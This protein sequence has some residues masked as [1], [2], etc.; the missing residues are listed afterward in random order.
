MVSAAHQFFLWI[1]FKAFEFLQPC[2]L[3]L[4]Y[5]FFL[6]LIRPLYLGLKQYQWSQMLMK[7]LS[8]KLKKKAPGGCSINIGTLNMHELFW[9]LQCDFNASVSPYQEWWIYLFRPKCRLGFCAKL[10]IAVYKWTRETLR[11]VDPHAIYSL[12]SAFP[13]YIWCKLNRLLN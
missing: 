4:V 9:M 6:S 10:G 13:C 11:C 12:S 5:F 1:P 2:S 7:F 8:W 3:K